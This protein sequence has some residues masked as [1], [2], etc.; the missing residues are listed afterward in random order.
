MIKCLLHGIKSST[1][2]PQSVRRFCLALHF[3]SPRAY[4]FIRDTFRKHL[5]HPNTL[6]IWYANSDVDGVAGFSDETMDKLKEVANRFKLRN[7]QLICSLLFDEMYIKKQVNWC[8]QSKSFSGLINYGHKN[9]DEPIPLAKQAIVFFLS[10]VNHPFQFPVAYYLIDKMTNIERTNLIRE[11][12]YKVT[13]C[14]IK[15]SNLTFDGLASNFTM[16]T[17]L[18]A[19]LDVLAD[20]FQPFFL[21][22]NSKKIYIILDPCHVEKLLRNQLANRGEIFNGNNEAIKWQY[23]IALEK[24]S[25][26]NGFHTHKVTKKHIQWKNNIMNVRIAVETLSNSVADSMECLMQQG[27]PEFAGAKA[28][29]EFVR[30]MNKLFDIFNSK[31]FKKNDL[32]KMPLC[33]QN[34][35]LIHSFFETLDSYIKALKVKSDLKST[36]KTNSQLLQPILSSRNRVAFRGLIINMK[37][38][39][40]MYE[41]FV[42]KSQT[43]SRIATYALSQDHLEIFFGKIRSL[44]GFNN[45]P[46]AQQ[47]KSAFRKLQ[48]N[49]NIK[50]SMHSNCISFDSEWETTSCSSNIYFVSSR[51]PQLALESDTIFQEQIVN[52]GKLLDEQ[53]QL[54]EFERNNALI[55][56]L[57][58]SVNITIAYIAAKI[59]EKIESTERFYCSECKLVFQEN[60]KVNNCFMSVK[61]LR[62]P[63]VSTFNIC[64]ET[65]RHLEF[66]D[67]RKNIKNMDG[68]F[69]FKVLYYLIFRSIDFNNLFPNTNFD[70]HAEHIYHFTKC[71]VNE[72]IKIRQTKVAEEITLEQHERMLRRRLNKLIIFSG[73]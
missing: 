7:E 70:G 35:R 1:K 46:N 36:K 55:D 17:E 23:F 34:Q 31:N 12:I 60:D 5:P 73:Q 26:E 28:T 41:E 19:N 10:G 56:T 20:S 71:I 6:V 64:K 59:E 21:N 18:G 61:S 33:E 52:Q 51:R 48:C 49:M 2:Y 62:I 53:L 57:D 4:E 72:Y 24:Y 54:N 68:S 38:L 11:I 50:N 25:R 42:V 3:H 27:H 58:G 30:Y 44:H 16:C 22:S 9:P 32:F 67:P 63:C 66:S 8:V 29:I 45:N 13:M 37:S 69:N 43:M 65:H 40:M 47:F 15:I 39:S 14:D